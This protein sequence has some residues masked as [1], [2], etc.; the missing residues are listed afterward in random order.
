M[1]CRKVIF[2]QAFEGGGSD[3][4]YP[5]LLPFCSLFCPNRDRNTFNDELY[6]EFDLDA[7]EIRLENWT[8]ERP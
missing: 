2:W 5:I 6:W 8:L 7:H 3:A 1:F 4:A